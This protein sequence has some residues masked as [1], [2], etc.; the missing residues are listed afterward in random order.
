LAGEWHPL[1]HISPRAAGAIAYLIVA[2]SIV[3]FTAYLWLLGRMPATTVT[4]YAYVNPVVALL[5]GH[6]IGSEAL[7]ARTLTGAAL[8][9]ASV[10]LITMWGRLQPAARP[11]KDY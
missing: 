1:P 3:A 5:L 7:A 11:L 6:F 10:L 2:G 9:L 8:V 4:S